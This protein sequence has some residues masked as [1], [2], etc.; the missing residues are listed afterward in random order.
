[1]KDKKERKNFIY[2]KTGAIVLTIVTAFLV[3]GA[4]VAIDFGFGFGWFF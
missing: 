2:T 4:A 1:M 3:A